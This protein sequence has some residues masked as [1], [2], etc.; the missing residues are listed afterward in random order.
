MP[1]IIEHI[2]AIARQKMRDV[3]FIEFRRTDG[4]GGRGPLVRGSEWSNLAVRRQ[5]IEWL[6]DRRIVWRPCGDVANATVLRSY[7]G[8][9]YIELPFD[10]N[11]TAF[12]ELEAYLENPDGTMRLSGAWFCCLTH[13]AAMQNAGHDE[14]G[15]WDRWADQF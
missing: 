9:I 12:Q 15:Y 6:N 5:I 2:D 8:Q 11:L 3:L 14:F 13:E 1:E 4:D 10:R 7:R